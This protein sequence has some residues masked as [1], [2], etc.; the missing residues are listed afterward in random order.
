MRLQSRK[1][2]KNTIHKIMFKSKLK[3]NK[4]KSSMYQTG[5]DDDKVLTHTVDSGSHD[6]VE[7]AKLETFD[8]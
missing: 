2:N 1:N 3:Y 4:K 5:A 8:S 7:G 6:K